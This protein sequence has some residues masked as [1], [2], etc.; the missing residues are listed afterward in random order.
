MTETQFLERHTSRD[1]SD[2]A[3]LRS[4]KVSRGAFVSHE[5]PDGGQ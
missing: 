3:L 4:N 5:S 2:N 1:T